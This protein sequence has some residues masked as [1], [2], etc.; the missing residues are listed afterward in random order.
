MF[1]GYKALIIFLVFGIILR[2]LDYK[3]K[4]KCPHQYYW[5]PFTEEYRCMHCNKLMDY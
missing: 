4:T 1:I 2:I 5:N 3:Y